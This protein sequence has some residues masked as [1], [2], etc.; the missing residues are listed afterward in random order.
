D[1]SRGFSRQMV[2]KRK[3][4]S[5]LSFIM[6]V[7]VAVA[8][9]AQ[10]RL[11]PSISLTPEEPLDVVRWK[12]LD[13]RLDPLMPK[14]DYDAIRARYVYQHIAPVLPAAVSTYGEL[15]KFM[16]RTERPTDIRNAE[17]AQRTN[18]LIAVALAM[19]AIRF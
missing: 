18:R 3:R 9:E 8:V 10:D 16:E 2:R 5:L 7:A 19:A 1:A 17:A 11:S 13:S 6:M 14:K 15:Q 12:D 4:V